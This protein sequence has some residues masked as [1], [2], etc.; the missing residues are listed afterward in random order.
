MLMTRAILLLKK[1][2]GVLGARMSDDYGYGDS[3]KKK[4]DKKKR[5]KLFP[6]R[7]GGAMR[8]MATEGKK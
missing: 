8:S 7:H 2:W 6:F 4:K 1:R 5:R 3:R